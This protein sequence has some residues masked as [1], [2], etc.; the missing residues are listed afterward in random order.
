MTELLEKT[1]PKDEYDPVTLNSFPI[2][3]KEKHIKDGNIHPVIQPKQV[4]SFLNKNDKK[5]C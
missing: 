2:S 5:R 1:V 3:D 4:R